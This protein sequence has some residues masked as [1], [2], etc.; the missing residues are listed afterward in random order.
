MKFGCDKTVELTKVKFEVSEKLYG[1]LEDEVVD[2]EAAENEGD[3]DVEVDEA[4]EVE[5]EEVEVG[6]VECMLE[7]DD[8][9]E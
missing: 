6:S 9:D 4:N 3:R 5:T 8:Q 2:G 7:K 1:Y